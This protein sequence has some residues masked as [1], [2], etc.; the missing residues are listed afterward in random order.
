MARN[1]KERGSSENPEIA[2][3][4]LIAQIEKDFPT[5]PEGKDAIAE[6]LMK[7]KPGEY[8]FALNGIRYTMDIAHFDEKRTRILIIEINEPQRLQN[9][10]HLYNYS[11]QTVQSDM[12]SSTYLTFQTGDTILGNPKLFRNMPAIQPARKLVNR[13]L[14]PDRKN[15]SSDIRPKK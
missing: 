1:S 6:S 12:T 9:V 4:E 15:P 2:A 8:R 5:L 10:V 11:A 7:N 14:K 3:K 13:I